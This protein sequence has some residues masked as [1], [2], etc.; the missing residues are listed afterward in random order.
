MSGKSSQ[1][2]EQQQ[3]QSSRSNPW[4]PT[5]PILKDILSGVGGQVSNY[6][7]N[8]NENAALGMLRQNAAGTQ[9]Y[10]AQA[11]GLANDLMTGGPD[12][13]GM[14]NDAYSQYQTQLN[15]YASGTNLD[16][17]QAPGMASVLDTIR[18]DVG[19]SINSMFAGAGRDL[20]GAHQGA[21]AR[22]LSQ[23]LAAPLLN[24]YN[25]N[26][27]NQLSSAGNLFNAGG[28]TAG[29]LSGMDQ[30]AFA[31]RGAGLDAAINGVPQAENAKAGNI[32]AAESYA[33][34][35]PLQ[36][37]GMLS[38]LVGPIAGLGGQQSGQSYGTTTGTQSMSPAQQAWGWMN[39]FSG[40]NNSFKPAGPTIKL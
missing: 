8:A 14:L 39:A 12:R 22:G 7:P 18:N 17:T 35:L 24:Q 38:G 15:P 4:E 21:I 32:L 6:Q 28:S 9:N 2:Q 34:N 19:N 23:G 11:T 27:Q 16:P 36:N 13:T 26:V 10:G 40:L 31:N 25:Q 37:L 29:M 30:Q 3:I 20:S 5:E 1:K 33:R